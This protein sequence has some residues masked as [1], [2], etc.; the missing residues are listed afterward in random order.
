MST[1][2]TKDYSVNI[3]PSNFYYWT[4]DEAS[5]NRIDSVAGIPLK[6]TSGVDTVNVFLSGDLAMIARGVHLFTTPGNSGSL[7]PR[8]DSNPIPHSGSFAGFSLAFWFNMTSI[9]VNDHILYLT[10]DDLSSVQ[11]QVGA[12][13]AVR[14]QDSLGF[15][16][17]LGFG[18]AL[19]SWR[20]VHIFYD[21]A[22]L[23]GGFSFNNGLPATIGPLNYS[24]AIGSALISTIA[25]TNGSAVYFDEMALKHGSEFTAAQVT[26]LYNGGSGR[27]W[28]IVLP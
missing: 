21:R 17:S 11:F 2:C 18:V 7:G 24:S 6:Y 22:T 9:D 12:A 23:A 28:P 5:G 26:Y 15:V 13:P 10:F 19:G 3:L 25:R 20:F 4:L 8:L 14:F 16:M 27:T 1:A